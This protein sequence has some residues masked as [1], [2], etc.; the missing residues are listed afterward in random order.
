MTKYNFLYA[1]FAFLLV[2]TPLLGS[3]GDYG[4]SPDNFGF[5]VIVIPEK[6][7]EHPRIYFTK[8]RE[9]EIKELMKTDTFLAQQVEGLYQKAEILLEE[10]RTKGLTDYSFPDGMRLLG[11]SWRL[12]ERVT[13]FAFVYRMTGKQE[14]ADA[15]IKEMVAVAQFKDWHPRHFLDTAEM[16]AGTALGYDWLYDVIPDE[17]RTIIR[18]G[19]VKHGLKPGLDFLKSNRHWVVSA[20]NWNEVCNN[21]MILAVLAIGDE[22]RG[23][24]SQVF[25]HAI[26]SMMFGLSMYA[27]EGTY[28]EGGNYWN[29][30]TLASCMT[31]AALMDVCGK[32]YNFLRAPGFNQTGDYFMSIVRP[33][34]WYFNYSNCPDEALPNP[35]MFWLSKVFNRPDYAAWLCHFV[36]TM[37][38]YQVRIEDSREKDE[39]F[40][41]YD[42][43][44]VL[45]AL[46]YNPAAVDADFSNT[47]LAKRS[48]GSQEIVTMRTAWQDRN[49]AYVGFKAGSNRAGHSHLDIGTFVYD[50]HGYRWAVDLGRDMASYRQ[51][52]LQRDRLIYRTLNRGHNTLL[53]DNKNQN[54]DASCTF[55]EFEI[56]VGDNIGRAVA[57]LTEAY[58]GQ[59]TSFIRAVTLK[60]DGTMIVEDQIEGAAAPVRWGMVTPA[61]IVFS[62]FNPKTATLSQGE[63]TIIAIVE[64]DEVEKFES[65]STKPDHAVENQNVGYSML[66]FMAFP[67]EGK[68]L[69]KVVL[70]P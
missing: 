25:S 45:R 13:A 53:I 60:K 41:N 38:Y 67:K 24:S 44:A 17:Q 47:P 11:S 33:D 20:S 54:L 23:I 51:P 68:I 15:A 43:Y 58:K 70:K 39:N 27:P 31:I 19:L 21:G 66:G 59:L 69:L 26:K 55:T 57:D 40:R 8:Q 48:K 42:R 4:Y 29:Y 52:A 7:P 1:L 5:N 22:E 32:D 49:A 63:S 14:Y 36:E 56:G 37:N 64:S 35:A 46:W 62:V 18:E 16:S 2:S 65:F 61:T 10:Q 6:F 30:G 50:I 28:P 9:A 12:I 34:F 3:D